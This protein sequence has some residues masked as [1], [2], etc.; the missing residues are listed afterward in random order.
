[1][2]LPSLQMTVMA[3]AVVLSYFS[4]FFTE[5]EVERSMKERK[6]PTG[7]IFSLRCV[8]SQRLYKTDAQLTSGARLACAI[9]GR[10][11]APRQRE[12]PSFGKRERFL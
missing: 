11:R 10:A 4:S 8:H 12:A 7:S 6:T 3:A 2:T 9:Y 5:V 1:M